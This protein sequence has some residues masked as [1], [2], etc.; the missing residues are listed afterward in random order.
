[1]EPPD[2]YKALSP[3]PGALERHGWHGSNESFFGNALQVE[4]GATGRASYFG[5]AYY[6][7]CGCSFSLHG[8]NPWALSSEEL[9]AWLADLDGGEHQYVATDY[10]FTRI[11]VSL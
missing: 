11:I 9:F 1:M 4:Y 2:I 6:P 10:L 8:I 5:A 3:L 7:G